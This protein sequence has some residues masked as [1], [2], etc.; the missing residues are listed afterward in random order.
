VRKVGLER[1]P[2]LLAL[3]EADIT[4][5]GYGEDP[6]GETRE[7]RSRIEQ[8]A[9][10]DAALQVKDLALDGADVMRILAIPPSRRVGQIL[11]WLLEKVLDDPSLNTEEK[12]AELLRTE[13][14]APK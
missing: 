12:L 3:R 13:L 9:A 4:G 6:A 14:P 8:V 10:E 11:E 5:R 2:A 7:L 1:L